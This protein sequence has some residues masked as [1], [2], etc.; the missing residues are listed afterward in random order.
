MTAESEPLE[1]TYMERQKLEPTIV[2]RGDVPDAMAKYA[3]DKLVAL[4]ADVS[5][6]IHALEIRLVHHRDPARERPDHVE[7]TVDLDGRPVRARRSAPSMAE[8]IDRCLSR[9]RRRVEAARE[10]PRARRLRHRDA[11]SWHHGD[12]PTE[13]P[14]TYA[15]PFEDRMLVRRKTFALKPESIE[16]ALD[17]LEALD[18]DFFLFVHDQSGTEALVYRTGTADGYGLMQRTATPD[19]V[20]RIGI[21]LEIGPHP[22]STSLEL[23]L[24]ILDETDAPFTFFVDTEN[25]QG[26]VAYG[27]DDGDYGLITSA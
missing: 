18:H 3:R 23:A 22:A 19:A 25:G 10:R 16:E 5:V 14:L 27:R 11:E 6:P 20:E 1:G 4:V 12:P 17:D 24:Q 7:I 9:L 15:R 8:A 13:R 26:A 21:P 2:V